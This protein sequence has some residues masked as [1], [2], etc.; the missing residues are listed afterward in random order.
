MHNIL[1]HKNTKSAALIVLAVALIVSIIF[2]VSQN[3]KAKDYHQQIQNSYDKAVDDISADLNKIE[4]ELSKIM[5]TNSSKQQNMILSEV[6]RLSSKAV[7]ELAQLPAAYV[8][9]SPLNRLLVQLG[10]YSH[11][12]IRALSDGKEIDRKDVEQLRQMYNVMVD[13]NRKLNGVRGQQVALFKSM[14][15]KKSDY[16]ESLD[17]V[18]LSFKEEGDHGL[19]PSL[20][21]DGPFSDSTQKAKPQGL[22]DKTLDL[23]A[24]T[25]KLKEYLG[26]GDIKN[27]E[28]LSENNGQVPSYGFK[29]EMNDNRILKTYLTKQGGLPLWLQYEVESDVE[30]K[31]PDEEHYKKLSQ[32]AQEYLKSFGFDC[33]EATYAQYY[34]GI[35][36]INFAF[37]QDEVILYEDLI[38]V[39]MDI[40]KVQPIGLDSK[41]YLF[42]HIERDLPK[43]E[44]TEQ[45]AQKLVSSDLEILSV[46]KA[47]IPISSKDERL[48][49]EFKGN[50]GEDSF[51]VYINAVTGIEEQIF[52]IIDSENGQLVL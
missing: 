14:Q 52:K 44:L 29:V 20:I 43:A 32:K 18:T 50:Y 34:N 40:E 3:A 30:T 33:M 41:N 31:I 12:L 5:V 39:W 35:V 7:G 47:L 48:C 13:I 51:I 9:F 4:T 36:I 15:S 28:N 23:N 46:R 45:E 22:P 26:A 6:W 37:V 16:F 27:I 1:K 49:Y 42:S 17:E 21:Y 25:E 2:S 24:A 38:K 8:D 11:S 10:D 19:Y